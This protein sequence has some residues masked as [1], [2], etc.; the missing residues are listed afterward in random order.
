MVHDLD[1]QA[2]VAAVGPERYRSATGPAQQ[3]A[4]YF[5]TPDFYK[6][7]GVSEDADLP[8]AIGSLVMDSTLPDLAKMALLLDI[9][10]DLPTYGILYVIAIYWF[11][12]GQEAHELFWRTAREVLDAEQDVRAGPLAYALAVDFFE[13]GRVVH[14]AWSALVRDDASPRLL[15]RMLDNSGPVPASLREPL[16]S[17]LM[18]DP[19]WH[20]AI[21]RSLLHSREQ[22]HERA[23][24]ERALRILQQLDVPA[25]SAGLQELR[26]LLQSP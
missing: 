5:G 11:D 16:Y 6:A 26:I 7:A 25:D 23:D 20:P 10:E 4:R 9:H 13:D 21:L 15:E 22:Y 17:R 14:E 19:A 1:K 12:F 8:H 24:K 3:V 18:Q 2:V